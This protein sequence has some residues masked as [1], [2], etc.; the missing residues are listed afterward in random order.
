[1]NQC[2]NIIN[3][4]PRNKLQWNFN[5]NLYI[6]I[7][8]NPFENFVWKMA[9]ILSQP[10]RVNRMTRKSEVFSHCFLPTMVTCNIFQFDENSMEYEH[11]NIIKRKHF[12]RYQWPVNSLRKASD[13]E[14]WCFLWSAPEQ[15]NVQTLR[16]QWF[17]MPSRSLWHH[18]NDIPIIFQLLNRWHRDGHI[19][20]CLLPDFQNFAI[21]LIPICNLEENFG[22]N[23]LVRQ[24]VLLDPGHWAMR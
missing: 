1:M 10:R 17:Q 9:A 18:C 2:W 22:Q 19:K 24:L 20:K 11:D 21:F 5:R 23:Q 4:T 15:T 6:F 13:A 14:L 8:E 7:Q 12:P 16:R 3:W